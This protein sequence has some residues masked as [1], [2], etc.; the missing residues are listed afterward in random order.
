MD[1]F[2]AFKPRSCFRFVVSSMP[3]C[4][5]FLHV[6]NLPQIKTSWRWVYLVFFQGET[7]RKVFK[8]SSCEM[9][10][11]HLISACKGRCRLHMTTSLTTYF[12]NTFLFIKHFKFASG[13]LS[14]VEGS[15]QLCLGPGLHAWCLYGDCSWTQM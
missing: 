2:L 11:F 9:G 6:T 7:F 12:L 13:I 8:W 10:C 15:L 3:D 14:A 1:L 5:Y 4:L